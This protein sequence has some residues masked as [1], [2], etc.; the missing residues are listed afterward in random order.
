[1]FQGELLQWLHV[2]LTRTA[3]DTRMLLPSQD[4]PLCPARRGRGTNLAAGVRRTSKPTRI[5][6]LFTVFITII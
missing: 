5:M 6:Y 3:G 4:T 1:M 2:A